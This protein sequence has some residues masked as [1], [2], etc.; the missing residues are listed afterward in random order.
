MN[1]TEQ[2]D[3]KYLRAPLGLMLALWSV[4]LICVLSGG[5]TPAALLAAYAGLFIGV[6]VGLFLALP[7]RKR[8]YGRRAMLL[9]LGSLLLVVALTSDHG[10]MQIEGLFF[11]A[12]AGFAPYIILHYALAKVVGPL[13][14]GRIWCGW[15]CW[16]AML[17]DLLPYPQSRYRLPGGLDRL[18]YVHFAA[19]LILVLVVWFGFGYEGGALGTSGM[20]WFVTGLLLYYAAGVGLAFALRDNRAFCKY[21]C[22]IAVLPKITGRFALLKIG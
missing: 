2:F 10:N 12:L 11:G 4:A 1:R 3:A 5:D 20:A 8:Q 13:L 18:R 9:M 21:L 7:D 14:F 6:G 19:S 17:F 16:F 15:A 22:P